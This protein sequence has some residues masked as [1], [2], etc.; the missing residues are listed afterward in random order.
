M[1]TLAYMT[2][3]GLFRRLITLWKT[4]V[5]MF[6]ENA[7]F[8]QTLAFKSF[9]QNCWGTMKATK[10]YRPSNEQM[11]VNWHC[12]VGVEEQDVM[13]RQHNRPQLVWVFLINL[14]DGGASVEILNM[15]W[16]GTAEL[17]SKNTLV[18]YKIQ[19]ILKLDKDQN[20]T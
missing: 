1:E 20:E 6:G 16:L 19:K 4:E 8:H 17:C 5:M 10:Q 14:C 15:I 11:L 2:W 12:F 9:Q 7:D 18:E 3:R 13:G